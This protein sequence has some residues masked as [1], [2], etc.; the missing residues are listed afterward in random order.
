M[1][2]YTPEQIAK[3]ADDLE[4]KEN[5]KAIKKM[6]MDQDESH[7]WPIRGRFNVTKRAFGRAATFCRETGQDM[8]GL[9]YAM[10]VDSIISQIVN[11]PKTF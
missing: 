7:L 3:Y 4:G 8:V 2:R 5:T 1:E 6:F 9:E 10:L 11:D